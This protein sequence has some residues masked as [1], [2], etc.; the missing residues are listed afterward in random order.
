MKKTISR[1]RAIASLTVASQAP[2]ILRG[3]NLN[4]ELRLGLVGMGGRGMGAAIQALAAS[5]R[6]RLH[7]VGDAFADTFD[8]SGPRGRGIQALSDMATRMFPGRD[9]LDVPTSRQFVGLD[10]YAHVIDSCDAV[11]LATPPGFRPMHFTYAVEQGKHVFLEKPA[12]TDVP[13]CLEMIESNRTAKA[14]K[15][16]CVTGFQRRFQDSYSLAFQKVKEEELIGPIRSGTV[17]WLATRPWVNA[18]K[19]KWSEMEYQVRNWIYFPWLSIEA[20]L[21]SHSHNID[22]AV[23]LMGSSPISATAEG[24]RMI[25]DHENQYGPALD[26]LYTDFTFPGDVTIRSESRQVMGAHRMVGEVFRGE[27]GILEMDRHFRITSNTGKTIWEYHRPSEGA[28]NPFQAKHDAWIGSILT[29]G[30]FNDVD[31]AVDSTLASILARTAAYHERTV[32][33]DEMLNWKEKFVPSNPDFKG[34]APMLAGASGHYSIPPRPL[35]Q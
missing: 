29:G 27:E 13:G 6:V 24:G 5:D 21:D 10:A 1:R 34:T 18:R 14:K 35:E 33:W 28:P 32:T 3:Q 8:G 4:S 7:A 11:L 19:P 26:Y 9:A 20:C 23:R 30:G 25:R 2:A 16:S 12:G 17:A 31:S 15:L 22:V